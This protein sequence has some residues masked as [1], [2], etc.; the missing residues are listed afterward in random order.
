M[1]TALWVAII[2]V[3]GTLGAQILFHKFT[4]R[5]TQQELEHAERLKRLE[6]E[7]A[8]QQR[9]R[10]DRRKAYISL[11]RTAATVD[12]NHEYTL[13]ELAEGFAE[14]ELVGGSDQA[15]R[16]ARDLSTWSTEA[17]ARARKAKLENREPCEDKDVREALDYIRN[18]RSNF[19]QVARE[20]IGHPPDT[21]PR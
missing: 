19:V 17:R 18:A 9:L 3:G 2:G 12:P 7:E 15:I 14:I 20:D 8:K 4:S 6:L 5:R 1:D 10:D 11:A 21:A 16:H 13:T